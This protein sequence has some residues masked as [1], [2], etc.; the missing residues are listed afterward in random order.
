MPE[1]KPE[2]SKK[3]PYWISKN[4]FYELKHFCLQ[5]NEW[6]RAYTA[7]DNCPL[8]SGGCPVISKEADFNDMTSK[9]AIKK[10]TYAYKIEL[11]KKTAQEADGSLAG[12][13]LKG[14]T[15]GIS[16]EGLKTLHNIPC[17]RDMY[18]DRY[19]KFFWLLSQKRD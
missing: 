12:Y 1:I 15:E 11:L 4:R 3:N 19:R 16:F 18:Y 14:V 5:Y 2:L 8:K 10:A 17:E 13:I 6:R 7:M 9:H